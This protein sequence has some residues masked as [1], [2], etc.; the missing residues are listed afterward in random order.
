MERIIKIK[1]N[2]EFTRL[3]KKGKFFIG[4]HMILYVL[5]NGLGNNRVG[6]TTSKKIGNSVVRN[7]S[8]RLIM[9]SYRLCEHPLKTGYD[10]VFVA[11]KTSG[12]ISFLDIKREMFFLYKKLNLVEQ[13]K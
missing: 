1:K 11:R 13:E 7:R 2:Y 3:Y 6:I 9:E 5:S 10:L 4:K 12:D 8:R